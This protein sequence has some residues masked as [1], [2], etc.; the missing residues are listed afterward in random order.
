MIYKIINFFNMQKQKIRLLAGI[1][2]KQLKSEKSFI[3]KVKIVCL[4]PVRII[5]VL[6]GFELNIQYIEIVL[7]TF[8]NLKCKG[9]SALM[10]YYKKPE[11]FK[12]DDNIKALQKLVDS[13]DCIRHLRLLGGEVLC[14]P[15]LYELLVYLKDQEKI[16]RVALVTNG[17]MI[18][19]DSRLIEI[20][21][22]KKFYFSISNY[23]SV[24]RNYDNLIKQLEDNNIEYI[25]MRESY[26]WIDYGNLELRNR[27]E[28]QLRKQYLN[29]T[30][31]VNS[32]LNG[33]LFHCFRCSHATNLKLIE[34]KKNDY[35]DL[36]DESISNKKMKKKLYKFLYKYTP[37][38]ESCKHCDCMISSK[39]IPR[40][41]QK[42]N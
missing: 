6:L 21:K 39:T 15:Y 32:L 38:I 40:G 22:D 24:S 34:L 1:V 9:C 14:Y 35:V 17:T 31:R 29:C 19:K 23:G 10:G 18:L 5:K 2:K 12:V 36:F 3:K 7:T 26:E 25:P 33:K 20:L 42:T 41:K 11:H 13:C 28:K 37:Y 8:C 30:H 4:I 27:S 16:E